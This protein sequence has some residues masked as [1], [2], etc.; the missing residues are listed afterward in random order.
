VTGPLRGRDAELVELAGGLAAAAAGAGRLVVVEGPA[1][2]GKTT[3]LRAATALARER[4]MAVLRA[5]GNP[6][7][8]DYSFGVA[9]QAF[10]PLRAGPHWP[11]VCRGPAA[12]AD[13]VLST[14]LPEPASNT[15]AMYAATHGLYWLAVNQAERSPTVLFVDDAHWTD[16]PSLRWLVGLARS[17]EELPLTLV[18]AVRA[19]APAADAGLV[20]ELVACAAGPAVRLGPLDAGPAADLVRAALPAA[21]PAFARACHAAA[22]GNPFLL[23][24]LLAHLRAERVPP[25]EGSVAALGTIGPSQVGRWVE[26]QLRRLPDGATALARALA[27]LG[28]AATL[29]HAAALAGVDAAA[30]A[31]LTDAMRA[32]GILD[33]SQGPGA[34]ASGRALAMAH[35]IVATALYEGIGPGERGLWHARAARLLAD[36]DPERAAPHL[37]RAHPTGDGST[38]DLLREAAARAN[39]RGAPETAVTY[40][41]RALAEPPDAA[42]DPLVRLDLAL[43]LAAVRGPGA[44]ELARDVV[45]RID[46]PAARAEAALRCA[47]ALALAG[48]SEVAVALHRLVLDRPAGVPASTL[49]RVAAELAAAAWTDSRTKH[50]AHATISAARTDPPPLPLWRVNAALEATFA[51]QPAPECLA[52]L[53]PALDGG[54]LAGETDSLLPTVAGIV[55]VATGDLGRARDASEAVVTDAA[56]RGWLSTVAHGRFMRAWAL[57]PAGAV[58]DAA[59]D[60]RAALDFKLSSAT[61][62]AGVLWALAPLV[63]ALVEADRPDA[64]EAAIRSAGV[65]VPPEHTL[66]SAMFLQSRARLRLAQERPADAGTDLDEAAARF[67]ELDISHPAIATWR[68]DAVGVLLALDRRADATRLAREHLVLAE[69]AGVPGALC[70]A[71][72]A[73]ALL[74]PPG[75]RVELLERAVRVTA[76][77]PARLQHAYALYDLGCALRRANRRTEA[78]E[79]LRG[80]LDLADAGGAARLAARALI[81]LHAAGARP[82]RTAL[83]GPTALTTAERQVASLAANGY[84]NRQIAQRLT[85][86]R[87][88][89]ETHLAH[90]Y[91]KLDIRSRAELAERFPAPG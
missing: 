61:P 47:R 85:L 78:R 67:A 23:T 88:T 84:T 80:A 36:G 33:A 79:P 44:A 76:D 53:A 62:V 37:L 24:A 12:L 89:I 41:R 2:I 58:G 19:G 17:V 9:R 90:A 57:L 31:V 5:R 49:A 54:I 39:A 32:T 66:I 13:R 26:Q 8:R 38:V 63:D 18:V 6:L 21:D 73:G 28:P 10:A 27:V 75:R 30:A 72:R 77:A 20:A 83:R 14:A 45:A 11:E 65:D 68:A 51:G 82:R 86:S 34:R 25:D 3:L 42:A 48:D 16:P 43:A 1:G 40:L 46:A 50:L 29:R 59:A 56:A 74:A 4:G 60:A 52:L 91:R 70:A 81:E 55:L 22:G 71:L 15:D 35:P 64:A 7:E 87:R 69:R